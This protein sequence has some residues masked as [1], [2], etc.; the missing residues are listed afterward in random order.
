MI[1]GISVMRRTSDSL[2]QMLPA[3]S[4]TEGYKRNQLT[5]M[6][7]QVGQCHADL[8]GCWDTE[9]CEDKDSRQGDLDR[10]T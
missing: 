1:R 10:N 8:K 5:I 3:S 4:P 6:R 7:S 9:I 2:V